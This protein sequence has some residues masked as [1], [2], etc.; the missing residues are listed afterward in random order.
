MI[1]I[2]EDPGPINNDALSKAVRSNTLNVLSQLSLRA[3]P[4]KRA[5]PITYTSVRKAL[6]WDL[7]QDNAGTEAAS[8]L[9]YYLF[10]DWHTA[11]ALV[12]TYHVKLE[13]LVSSAQA[14][15]E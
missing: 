10:D 3:D 11:Y 1:S 14:Q 5:D 7:L 2:H 6:D 4:G 9:F 13:H 15:L 12:K 8:N